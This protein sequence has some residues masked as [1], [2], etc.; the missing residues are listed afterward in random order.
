MKLKLEITGKDVPSLIS[1]L[2]K[3][4]MSFIDN[5][6]ERRIDYHVSG[7]FGDDADFSYDITNDDGSVIKK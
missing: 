1:C 6:K 2:R 5:W 3:V 7:H 4:T